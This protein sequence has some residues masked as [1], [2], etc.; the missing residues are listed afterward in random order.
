[1]DADQ[2]A[3]VGGGDANYTAT[4]TTQ[5]QANVY[6]SDYMIK[7]VLAFDYAVAEGR[8]YMN[9]PVNGKTL[10]FTTSDHE[11]G[12]FTLTGLHDEGDAQENGTKIRTYAG[13][14]A[15]ANETEATYA[16]PINIIRGDG[17]D[18]GWF[19][20]YT[21]KMFQNKYYPE[22][23]SATAKRIVVAYGSN[24]LTNGN[25]TTAG[26]TPGN[27][28]PQD[29]WVGG[30]DNTGSHAVQITGR[31]LLDNTALTPIM[32]DF[33]KLKE[34]KEN[35]GKPAYRIAADSLDYIT[36]N[37]VPVVDQTN[38]SFEVKTP[39]P[40]SIELFD[41]A[42]NKIK[43]VISEKQYQIGKHT[44]SVNGANLKAGMYVVVL[45][46][47]GTLKSKKL[48]KIQ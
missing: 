37:P 42:G 20:E 16:T 3:Y 24:P 31:G 23:A 44:V 17:G 46:I 1:V 32:A 26:G 7:E 36:I 43:T 5:R 30:E 40:V 25:S 11:C 35:L 39:S 15:K 22:P 18:E 38:V 4:P 8:A 47:N 27:H 29:I 19:P 9:V 41:L 34:F 6:G 28:T 13:E 12:G 48:I 10:I 14:I 33:L 2:A 45:N 21:L